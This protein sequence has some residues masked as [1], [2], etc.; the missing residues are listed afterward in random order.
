MSLLFLFILKNTNT[1]PNL[2]GLKVGAPLRMS[3][4]S[5]A[6]A[7]GDDKYI[8]IDLTLI[9]EESDVDKGSTHCADLLITRALTMYLKQF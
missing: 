9:N 2:R 3:S 8:R 4:K 5:S 1:T 7:Q 6:V